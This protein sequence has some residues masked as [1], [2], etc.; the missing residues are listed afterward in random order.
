MTRVAVLDDW[1]RVAPDSADWTA[2]K[3]RAEV[4]FF[5]TP[6]AGEDDVATKLADFDIVMAMRERTAFPASLVRRLPKLRMFNMTGARAATIDTAT[7]AAQGVTV[8]YTGGGDQGEA[9]AELALG[10]M[11]AAARDIPGGDAAIRSGRFQEGVRVGFVL[12]GKTLGVIG[13]GRLG[14]LMA[15]YGKAL[16]MTVLAWSQNLTAERA[17]A[18]GATLVSKEELLSRADVVSLHLVLSPRSRGIIGA[19]ELARM[20][21][22]AI[23]VN[24][25]RGPLVDAAALLEAVQSG[26]IIAALD[27]YDREPLAADDRLR[28][29][30]NTALTPHLGYGS[31][32]TFERFH[33]MSIENVLAFLDGKPIRVL[34][35]AT[36]S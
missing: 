14:A 1:Q 2:L 31:R 16:G 11:L 12:A 4:V 18:V 9:T 32:E 15:G 3:A 28:R 6:F 8:C 19:A 5:D 35:T 7:L 26:R 17:A 10:L 27:V 13:L 36:P 22:G 21:R 23:L 34:Q 20:K 30:P 33:A 24:T 25:S 29:A